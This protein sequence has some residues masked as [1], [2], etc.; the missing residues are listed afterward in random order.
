MRRAL[1]VLIAAVALVA[2]GGSVASAFPMDP[3]D[4]AVL[5]EVVAHG[6]DAKDLV[7][8]RIVLR[9]RYGFVLE[10]RATDDVRRGY[11]CDIDDP[12]TPYLHSDGTRAYDFLGFSNG[13]T[14]RLHRDWPVEATH[15]N[16]QGRYALGAMVVSG[17]QTVA[18]Y[19]V[20]CR[21]RPGDWDG[22]AWFIRIRDGGAA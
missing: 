18:G 6:R 15:P 20:T 2:V 5:G 10:L 16:W 17:G 21:A 12:T 14:S 13:G 22:Q 19:D 3:N 8:W 4:P 1:L 11:S 9:E 7:R